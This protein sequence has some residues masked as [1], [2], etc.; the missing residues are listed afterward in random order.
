MGLHYAPSRHWMNDPNGLI[1]HRGTY[2]LFYQYNPHGID[3]AD[4]SWG[5]ASSADLANWTEHP[6]AI[7]CDEREEIFSGSAVFDEHNT[8]GLG[9]AQAPP[10]VAIYTTAAREDGIQAQAIAH[11]LDDGLTWHKHAGNPVL[12]RGSTQFRDPKVFR[13]SGAAESY[14]VMVA[15]EA[16]QQQVL[17]YRSDDLRSWTPLSEF[18]PEGAVGG[19]WECPDLFPLAVDDDPA[20]VRWVLLVSLNPGGVAGGSATQYFVGNFDGVRFTADEHTPPRDAS[21]PELDR[22]AWVDRGRDCYAGVTFSGM[23]DDE[24]LFIAWMGNWDYAR[25]IP[26]SPARGAMTVPRRLSLRRVDGR[27]VLRQAPVLPPPVAEIAHADVVVDGVWRLPEPIAGAAVVDVEL[28]VDE[29]EAVALRF[30]GAD[31]DTGGVVVVY[32]RAEGMLRVD[33]TAAGADIHL[34]FPSVESVRVCAGLDVLALRIVLDRSSIEVFAE[35]GCA[36]V[37]DLFVPHGD[38]V[39]VTSIGGPVVVRSLRIGAF[40]G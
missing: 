37:T 26:P 31:D 16:V 12:D 5:H 36:V 35:D 20:D 23:P 38:A 33:R 7:P 6:V 3:H 27:P 40:P 8:S 2:H 11:S 14:W 4:L 9:T 1:R 19:V 18:G 15:V 10:L 32:E 25:T 17:L 24:R 39:T 13:W 29:A 34:L 28:R 21:H 30:L 22:V